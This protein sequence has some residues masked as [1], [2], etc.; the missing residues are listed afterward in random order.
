MKRTGL[1]LVDGSCDMIEL[2]QARPQSKTVKE[3]LFRG[4]EEIITWES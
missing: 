4:F 3:E 1:C 2:D